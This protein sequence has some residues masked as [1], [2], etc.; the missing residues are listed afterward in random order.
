MKTQQ[1]ST[2][3]LIVRADGSFLLTKRSPNDD[4]MPSLWE[5]PGGGSEY[6][7]TPEEATIREIQ[8]EC[9]VTVNVHAPLATH[10]HILWE[11]YNE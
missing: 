10:T 1:V 11:N 5:I 4:F 7:E 2:S 9:G 3:A 6:G 8:E